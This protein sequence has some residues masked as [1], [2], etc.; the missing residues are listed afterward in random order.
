M[1]RTYTRGSELG[2]RDLEA[3][4]V[5]NM[6]LNFVMLQAECYNG[7]PVIRSLCSLEVITFP[8]EM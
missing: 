5:F 8:L 4:E 3:L 1:L 7:R 6:C 2:W